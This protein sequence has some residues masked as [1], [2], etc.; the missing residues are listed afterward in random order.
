[1]PPHPTLFVR[2]EV[3]DR[4][5]IYDSSYRIA[6]DYD[7]ILRWFSKGGITPTYLA[8]VLAKMRVGGER[9]QSIGR[10]LRKSRED[11]CALRST[12][13]GGIGALSWTNLSK[14]PQFWI[15]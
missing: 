2:R 11:Y 12:G 15:K 3:F 7:A 10:I 6:A 1:M 5:G 9:S 4:L 13:V 14:L 8:T